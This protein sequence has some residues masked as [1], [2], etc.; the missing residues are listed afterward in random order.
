[1]PAEHVDAE[2]KPIERRRRSLGRDVAMQH[3]AIAP[4][5]TSNKVEKVENV[6][7]GKHCT[8]LRADKAMPMQNVLK[9]SM[10][11]NTLVGA[12]S[13]AVYPVAVF[14]AS[15]AIVSTWLKDD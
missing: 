2:R 12:P 6:G 11:C 8:A 13:V 1:M 9:Q 5:N 14:V 15:L 10:Y 3:N 7:E 4:C